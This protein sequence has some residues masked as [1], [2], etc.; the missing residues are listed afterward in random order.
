V[1]A[2]TRADLLELSLLLTTRPG[3]HQGASGNQNPCPRQ[4]V[5]PPYFG[6]RLSAAGA[7]FFSKHKALQ[8]AAE[9]SR[10]SGAALQKIN[11]S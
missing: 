10:Q 2:A 1:N 4:A 11:E 8:A 9:A 5:T 6:S 7:W 3:H